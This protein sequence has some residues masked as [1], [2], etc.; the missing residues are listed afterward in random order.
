MDNKQEEEVDVISEESDQSD[1]EIVKMVIE[2]P[3]EKWDCES[4]LSKISTLTT[5]S[6]QFAN[7]IIFIFVNL[8]KK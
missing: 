7:S 2:E 5:G 3:Q 4:I 1:T 6:T 8:D